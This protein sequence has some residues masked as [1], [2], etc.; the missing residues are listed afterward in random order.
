MAQIRRIDLDGAVDAGI[1][2]AAQADRLADFLGARVP[3]ASERPRFSFVHVLY[4]L[5]G[6]I[7]IG[8]MSLFMTISWTSYG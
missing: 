8:A 7:A 3:A 2:T 4:Y 5:G 6:L 1:L